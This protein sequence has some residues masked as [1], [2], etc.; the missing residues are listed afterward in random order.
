MRF[1]KSLAAVTCLSLFSACGVQS[2]NNSQSEVSNWKNNLGRDCK[3][4][5]TKGSLKIR[6]ILVTLA[7]FNSLDI[8]VWPKNENWS[9]FNPNSKIQSVY[10]NK[11]SEN[12]WSGV[13]NTNSSVVLSFSDADDAFFVEHANQTTRLTCIF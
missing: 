7:N 5:I 6:Y 2:D 4:E 11:T 13:T 12:S 9:R 3:A 8:L 1:F 10:M